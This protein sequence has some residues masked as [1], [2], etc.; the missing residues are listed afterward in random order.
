MGNAKILDLVVHDVRFPTSEFLDGS[1]AM[2][3]DRDYSAAYVELRT[4]D[5]GLTGWGMTFTIGRGNEL[6]GAAIEAFRPARARPHA[7]RPR[8][9]PRVD[10]H[11]PH[12][13][14]PAAM[15]RAREGRGPPRHRRAGERAVGPPGPAGG[16]AAVE[17]PVRP[18]ARAGRVGRGLPPPHRRA[19]AGGRPRPAARGPAR[20]GAREARPRGGVPGVLTSAGWRLRRRQ[21]RR[22]AGGDRRRVAGVQDEGRP[23]PAGRP[24]ARPD[25]PRGDRARSGS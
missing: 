13:R 7:R 18:H 6:C 3:P 15:A 17:V 1:D 25:R 16:E 12:L 11:R 23:R 22:G 21:I 8:G 19:H 20:Q 4:D 14:Q 2:N 9:R 24:P 5:P 10:R